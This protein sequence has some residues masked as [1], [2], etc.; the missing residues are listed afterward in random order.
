[1][2][3][4]DFVYVTYITTT[5]EKLW[6]AITDGDV[7]QKYWKHRNISDWKPGSRWEHRS[8]EG[9]ADI[10]GKIVESDPPRRL[11]MTWARPSEA[12][13]TAKHS[14]VTFEIEPLATAV[15]LI[16]THDEL[17]S[18]PSMLKSISGGWPLVLSSLKSFL[19]TGESLTHL[20]PQK[21]Q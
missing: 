18:D 20:W 8:Q 6:T 16:V 19:E 12:E 17:E 13:E 3:R 21:K 10:V 11:V 5:P 9:N 7:T 1:V 2:K 15:R 4:P 14:R